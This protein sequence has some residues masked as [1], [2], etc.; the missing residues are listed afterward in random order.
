LVAD[1][2]ENAR[3]Y[4]LAKPNCSPL[5]EGAAVTPR[6]SSATRP[7]S[8]GGSLR[9]NTG[10]KLRFFRGGFPPRM[11]VCRASRPK[12]TR[13]AGCRSPPRVYHIRSL[14][15]NRAA[16]YSANSARPKATTPHRLR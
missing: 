13:I 4:A 9:G 12:D 7:L 14:P 8:Q 6:P 10:R 15:R 5:V 2:F 1:I 16:T 3:F 11:S